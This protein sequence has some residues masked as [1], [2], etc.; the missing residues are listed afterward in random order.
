[1]SEMTSDDAHDVHSPQAGTKLLSEFARPTIDEWHT[2]VERLLKGGPYEKRMLT[3]THE[4]IVLQ[5]LYRREDTERLPFTDA[6][7]GFAPYVRGSRCLRPHES[8]WEVAQEFS[9]PT[10]EEYNRALTHDLAHGLTAVNLQLDVACRRGLDPDQASVGEV[11]WDGVSIASADELGVALLDVDLEH[12]PI[13]LHSGAAGL[14]ALGLLGAHCRE[15]NTRIE[16]L[17]GA[18]ACDPLGQMLEHGGLAFPLAGAFDEL[19]AMAQWASSNAPSLDTVWVHGEI[20]NGAGANAV[21][22]LA[23]VVMSGIEYLRVLEARGVAPSVTSSHLG[24]SFGLGTNFFMEVAKL[25]AARLLWSRVLESCGVDAGSRAL[26]IHARTS[27]YSQTV[28]DPY[29]NMLRAA[30]E[31]LSGAV[32][33]V[34]SLDV[35][36]FD[37]PLRPIDEFSRRIARNTQLIVR[38]EAHLAQILDPAGGSWYVERLTHE[39]ATLAWELIQQIE[40]AGGML[41]S[42]RSGTPQQMVASTAQL[43][44]KALAT[45]KD[46]LVGTNQY[47]NATEVPLTATSL[48]YDAISNTRGKAVETYRQTQAAQ[49]ADKLGRVKSMSTTGSDVAEAMIEAAAVGATIGQLSGSLA[50]RVGHGSTVTSIARRR[51]DQPFADL[52]RAVE[53]HRASKGGM[54]VFLATLGPAGAYMPRLDFAASFFEVGGFEVKRTLGHDSPDEAA[55]AARDSGASVVVICGLD[56]SYATHASVLAAQLKTGNPRVVVVLAGLPSEEALR[57]KLSQGGVDAFIHVRSNILETL[58]DLARRLGV[59]L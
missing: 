1:M 48:D 54:R 21:Q 14:P 59:Q 8:A 27:R 16:K 40:K 36:P 31:A 57:E 33:G 29:V 22:E 35:A 25:R 34:D 56:E 7:P 10:A 19:A 6:P 44:D 5:P 20:Y 18:I 11:G 42:I 41:S 37:A 9:Y 45:R 50:T 49:S 46:I 39:L 2:E 3:H 55:R 24:V 51:A 28:Y 23:F 58:V 12:T 38:D 26:K 43:R 17:R 15:N 13:Y 32:G 53:A 52:R 47:P 30:T 4:G